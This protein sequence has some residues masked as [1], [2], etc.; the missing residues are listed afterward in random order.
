MPQE[1]TP[2]Q[3]VTA[4]RD[5]GQAE[6]TRADLAGKL[7]VERP[8][9]K[10]GFKAARQAGRLEKVRNDDEGTGVFRLTAQ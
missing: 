3:V 4:A 10:Q 7:E 1:I 5:L 8:A 9:I 6:F 2:D